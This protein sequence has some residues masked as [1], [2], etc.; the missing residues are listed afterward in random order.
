VLHGPRHGYGV[1]RLSSFPKTK[2]R[3]EEYHLCDF[4]GQSLQIVPLRSDEAHCT[5]HQ[6]PRQMLL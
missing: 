6:I 5:K 3:T 2:N 4:W 1:T